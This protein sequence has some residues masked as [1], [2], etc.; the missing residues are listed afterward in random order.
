[1]SDHH[2]KNRVLW[3]FVALPMAMVALY[4]GSYAALVERHKGT[5]WVVGPP[6]DV[7]YPSYKAHYRLLK[8]LFAPIEWLDVNYVRRSYWSE[9]EP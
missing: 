6:S 4:V 2:R 8:T 1:M 5:I 9:T 7:V 3:S